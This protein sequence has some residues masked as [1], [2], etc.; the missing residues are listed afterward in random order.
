M[1]RREVKELDEEGLFWSSKNEK[2]PS[3]RSIIARVVMLNK[4]LLLACFLIVAL[5]LFAVPFPD[6]P[7]ALIAAVL[8]STGVLLTFRRFTEE[9]EFVT[10]IFSSVSLLD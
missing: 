2:R 10:T 8:L 4:F 9:R 1:L 5:G 3:G 7:V 6:G